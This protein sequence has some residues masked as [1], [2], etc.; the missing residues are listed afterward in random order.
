LSYSISY[1]Q[2][3]PNLIAHGSRHLFVP[4]IIV[5]AP[6]HKQLG[7]SKFKLIESTMN[8]EQNEAKKAN[9]F[10]FLSGNSWLNK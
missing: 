4:L 8:H 3:L 10:R 5:P 7:Q 6:L 2:A 9:N 1:R